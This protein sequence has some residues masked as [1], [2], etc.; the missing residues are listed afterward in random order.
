[1][2]TLEEQAIELPETAF[3]DP[4]DC[5]NFKMVWEM[6]KKKLPGIEKL[7]KWPSKWQLRQLKQRA[8]SVK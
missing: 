3:A 8:K 5:E 6:L 7:T 1:M 2:K 4:Q